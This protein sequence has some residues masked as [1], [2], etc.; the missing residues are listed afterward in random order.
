MQTTH[1]LQ[2][3]RSIPQVP[4]L[5]SNYLDKYHPKAF[6]WGIQ[7]IVDG[8]GQF[9]YKVELSDTNHLYHLKFNLDGVLIS[10]DKESML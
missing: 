2:I 5:F 6:I 7:T 1:T 4:C 10:E 3:P 8:M 9:V